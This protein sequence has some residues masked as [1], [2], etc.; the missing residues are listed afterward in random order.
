MIVKWLGFVDFGQIDRGLEHPKTNRD[1][2]QV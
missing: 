1:V 2:A